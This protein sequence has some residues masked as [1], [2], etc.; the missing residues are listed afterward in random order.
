MSNVGLR[1][2]PREDTGLSP[3]EAVFSAQIVLPNEFLQNDEFPVDTIVKKISKTLH[4]SAPSLPRHN[5]CT[6]LPSELPAE[7]L[8]APLVLGPSGQPGSTPSAALRRPLCGPAQRPR[9]FTIRVRSRDEVVAVSCLKACT[10]TDTMPSSPSRRGRPPGSCPSGLAATKRVSFSDPLVSLP[11]PSSA[12]PRDG[13][14]TVFLPGEEV[15]A[16]KHGTHPV[17]GHRPRGWTSDLFSS[18]PR[19][20]LGGSPVENCLHPWRRPN[21]SGVL[22]SICTVLV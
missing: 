20:E 1:A 10:A 16:H 11:S 8:S 4:V 12:P 2:Q 18:Q 13:P 21:Q 15:F 6:E 19:P 22:K 14:G 5:C 17:S 9:S 3:A 7:L